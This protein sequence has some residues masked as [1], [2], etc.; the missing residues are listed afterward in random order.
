MDQ[1]HDSNAAITHDRWFRATRFNQN[2]LYIPPA[3]LVL[4][5]ERGMMTLA[6]D[7]QAAMLELVEELAWVIR[8]CARRAGAD[9]AD[10][11]AMQDARLALIKTV[12]DYD[13]HYGTRLSTLFY[14][15]ALKVFQNARQAKS[16]DK[17]TLCWSDLADDDEDD[18]PIDERWFAAPDEDVI[19]SADLSD[20]LSQLSHIDRDVI[21]DYFGLTEVGEMTLAQI[22]QKHNRSAEW[23][24]LTKE[25]SLR[26]LRQI[27][28]GQEM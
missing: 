1:E 4:K 16:L 24:R 26:V 17:A 14:Y 22:G 2:R 15:R 18:A 5:D 28:Q 11:D 6:D 12:Q 19:E 20:A 9:C 25:R 21:A 3:Y 8:T 27:Y 13:P 23:V 10:E 7:G